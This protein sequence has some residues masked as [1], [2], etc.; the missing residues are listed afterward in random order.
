L[1]PAELPQVLVGTGIGFVVWWVAAAVGPGPYFV[2]G[3]HWVIIIFGGGATMANL[4]LKRFQPFRVDV[5][6]ETT[7]VT[8]KLPYEADTTVGVSNENIRRIILSLHGTGGDADQYYSNGK[9]VITTRATAAPNVIGETYVIAPQF[10]TLDPNDPSK[11]EVSGSIPSDVLYW[12][13]GRASGNLSGNLARAPRS[14]RIRSFD[15]MDELLAQLCNPLVFPNLKIIVLIGQSNG[16][17]FLARYA[18]A[19]PI[20]DRFAR[21]Y[22]IHMR[23]VV[24]GSGSYLYMDD[25]RYTFVDETYKQTALGETWRDK[26]ASLSN[27]SSV[28]SEKA[29]EFNDWPCGLS[30]LW[31]Y[32]NQFGAERIRAQFGKRDV[33]YLVGENDLSG[34]FSEC[35][36]R[37]QG[38]DTLAKTLLYFYHLEQHYGSDL[39]HRLRVVANV[40]HWGL[41]TMTSPE[42]IEE[43]FRA[44]PGVGLGGFMPDYSDLTTVYG[45]IS[46]LQVEEV[47]GDARLRCQ[48]DV[49]GNGT[50]KT[51][52]A[53]LDRG[54]KEVAYGML[55]LMRDAFIHRLRVRLL[56]NANEGVQ[57]KRFY[58]VRVYRG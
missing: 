6:A 37:V 23:Y 27:F 28:C 45:K 13:G 36:E 24:M 20:E 30:S 42:G 21:P 5:T 38:P 55:D 8:P 25:K 29:D 15:I 57:W 58:D 18:A 1:N 10:F 12:S 31:N 11:D 46:R 54:N 2:N 44:R 9:Q 47:A 22:G 51:F 39:N 56:Y 53:F 35:P 50:Q 32:P 16:G 41:G 52:F 48:L 26:I 40:G 43:I 33:I 3:A 19:S 7:W 34:S 14:Y 49:E 4:A 17:R